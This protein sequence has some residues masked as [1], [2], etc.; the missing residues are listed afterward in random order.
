MDGRADELVRG[1]M[2][3]AA[4]EARR[5]AAATCAP[6]SVTRQ[7]PW[8][9]RAAVTVPWYSIVAPDSKAA[10]TCGGPPTARRGATG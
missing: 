9:V 2:G 8:K 1:R 6:P 10:T 7:R 5:R 3:W 4:R